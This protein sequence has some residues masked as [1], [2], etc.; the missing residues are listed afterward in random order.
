MYTPRHFQ[1]DR[2]D[3]LHDV[4][5]A[6]DF[7]LLLATMDDGGI[8]AAHIPFLLDRDRG[9]HGTLLAHVARANPIAAHL[10][11]SPRVTAVFQGPHGYVSPAWFTG[12]DAVPTWNYVAVHASGTAHVL[13]DPAAVRDML[14]RLVE[15]YERPRADRWRMT[16]LSAEKL[17]SLPR[18]IVAFEIPIDRLEGKV[19]LSQNKPVADRRGAIDGLRAEQGVAGAALANWMARYLDG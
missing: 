18:A 2:L 15:V 19:K 11:A 1:E 8:E 10:T 17:T 3:V 5:V 16:D 9:P 14:A 4:I 7:G 6:H 12:R 13:D